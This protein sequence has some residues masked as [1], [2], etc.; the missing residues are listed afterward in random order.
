MKG[1]LGQVFIPD[2]ERIERVE[3]EE[4][5]IVSSRARGLGGAGREEQS[6]QASSGGLVLCRGVLAS[7]LHR[8]L[9]LR[10]SS[11]AERD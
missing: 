7:S 4:V 8:Q 2:M 6:K 10:Y 5:R 9:L 11:R 1:Q 3:E